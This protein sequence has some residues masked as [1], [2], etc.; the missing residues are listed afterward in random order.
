MSVT[1]TIELRDKILPTQIGTYGPDDVVP[2]HHLLDLVLSVDPS[3]VLIPKDDMAH[4]FDYDPLVAAIHDVAGTGH[5]ATQEWLITEI[6]AICAF[7]P[8]IKSAEIYLRK[9]PVFEQSGTLGL[10][11][12]LSEDDLV[13]IRNSK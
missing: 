4:V 7:Y 5:R 9:F 13:N 1:S 8:D 3:Q 6:A 2:D 12:T 10:R 11:L